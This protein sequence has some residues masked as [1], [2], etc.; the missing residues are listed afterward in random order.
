M[1]LISRPSI[2]VL[3]LFVFCACKK[4]KGSS[5]ES[6]YSI[7][8][9]H[10]SLGMKE[11][12][13]DSVVTENSD[14]SLELNIEEEFYRFSLDELVEIA[15][16]SIVNFFNLPLTVTIQPG[17]QFLSQVNETKFNF[18]DVSLTKV[19]IGSGSIKVKLRS[20]IKEK[21]R[22]RYRIPGATLNGS[23][24]EKNVD[25]PAGVVGQPAVVE[26]SF[27][28]SGYM[29]DLTGVNKNLVNTIHSTVDAWVSEQGQAVA[30]T[31]GDSILIENTFSGLKPDYGH[32]YFGTGVFNI[33]LT[34]TDFDVFKNIKA[35]SID[36]DDATAEIT[37]TN[38]VGADARAKLVALSAENTRTG[39]MVALNHSIIGSTMNINRAIE[40]PPVDAVRVTH[41]N[42]SNSNIVDMIELL[43]D[44]MNYA[45][46][47]TINPLGNVSGGHDFI[48]AARPF[49][50][51]LNLR[52]PLNLSVAGLVLEDTMD[53]NFKESDDSERIKEGNI[54]VFIE[55]SFPFETSF[56]LY[57]LDENNVVAD[58]VFAQAETI[59]SAIVENTTFA[60][61]P[62]KKKLT[63]DLSRER[64]DLLPSV[65]KL[66]MR[67]I[68]NTSATPGLVKIFEH[69]KLEVRVSADFTYLNKW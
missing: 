12:L 58:S 55:N 46:D 65:K 26:Q 52:I 38:G 20:R 1:R 43:P 37:I 23:V 8:L 25:V 67:A 56:Q 53:F 18:G 4:E 3:F 40:N 69:Y 59:A 61:L 34:S 13:G 60:S 21:T 9:A 45:I 62:A 7:P 19:R 68:M 41:L 30:I 57:M 27:D 32:G 2:L 6:D 35:G 42:S 29:F 66:R 16:T 51:K 24:F 33:P 28:L 64:L 15:D 10:G 14:H 17:Q 22:V 44:R 5:W 63:I 47:L 39:A 11:I 31:A 54:N 36:I 49:K 50:A 48:D